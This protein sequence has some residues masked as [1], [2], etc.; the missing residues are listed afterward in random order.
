[1]KFNRLDQDCVLLIIEKVCASKINQN[2]VYFADDN[3][4]VPRYH[5]VDFAF[6][7]LFL[8]NPKKKLLSLF[9]IGV[10]IPRQK[11]NNPNVPELLPSGLLKL[12]EPEKSIKNQSLQAGS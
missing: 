11:P 6:K 5:E 9:I 10:V 2:R 12:D 4:T 1:M 7:L 8:Y 3:G